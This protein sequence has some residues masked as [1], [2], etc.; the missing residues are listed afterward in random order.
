[1]GLF[2]EL[3]KMHEEVLVGSAAHLVDTLVADQNHQRGE[4]V[5]VVEGV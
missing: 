3:T 4:F 5:V 1:V 2:R